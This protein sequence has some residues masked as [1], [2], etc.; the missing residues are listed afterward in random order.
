MLRKIHL[1]AWVRISFVQAR[2]AYLREDR[3]EAVEWESDM[4]RY[5]R[6][7]ERIKVLS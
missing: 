7:L 1:W 5:E 2:L 3:V 4:Y 6:E